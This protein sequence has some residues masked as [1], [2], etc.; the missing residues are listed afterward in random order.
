M[1]G[2]LLAILEQIEREKGIEKE[3][4]I[5]A[6]E[7]ALVIAAKKIAKITNPDAEISVKIDPSSGKIRAFVGEEEILSESLARI[8]AQTARQ[9]IIQKIREAEK[10]VIFNEFK[11]KVGSLIS[12]SVYRFEKN[13]VI[14]DLLGK[15]E[16]IIPKK[17]LSPLDSFKL[18]ERV[19]A[20]CLEVK[21]EKGPQVIASRRITNFVKKLFE[22]EV[23]EIYEG[24]VE[25]KSIARDPG[26]RTK[27]AVYSK[28][29]KVDCVGACVG[30][31]GSR[32]KNI[33]QELRGE[34]IDIVR[35]SED[36][37]EFIKAS[38]SPAQL[39]KIVLNK[40]AKRALVVVEK[41]Q[42]SLAIGKGG[43][44]VR[45]ASRLTGWELDI[46]SKE[47][48][49]KEMQNLNKLKGVGAHIIDS[50]IKSGFQ[51]LDSLSKAKPEDLAGIKGIGKKKASNIIAQAKK[52]LEK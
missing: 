39:S 50:L 27:I 47:E 33:V 52:L 10:E 17:E 18:G 8:A 24:I 20:Y 11:D 43:Q 34:K 2:E 1:N 29:D 48:L 25:I 7:Q 46:R 9:V 14:L 45:L 3:K 19:K 15:T 31:R 6:I 41:E 12:G 36:P 51:S 26:D 37:Q 16:A 44:N 5:S 13:G 21:K 49:K 22:L 30:M 28:D 40:E 4:L 38:L 23:P 42:L 35:Y 32:V